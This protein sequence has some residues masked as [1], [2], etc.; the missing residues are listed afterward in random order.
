VEQYNELIGTLNSLV[1]EESTYRSYPPLTAAQKKEMSEKEIELW[2]EKSKCGLVRNDANIESFLSAARSALYQKPEDCEFALYDI[3]IETSSD[4]SDKGKLVIDEDALKNMIE[5]NPQA[6]ES[7]FSSTQDGLAV[8]LNDIIKRTANT[9][10]GSIP[11]WPGRAASA[12]MKSSVSPWGLKTP[13]GSPLSAPCC[14]PLTSSTATPS[15]PR[16]R[17]R[18]W[19]GATMN[20]SSWT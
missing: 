6:I 20:N 5:S 19:P 4:W 8:T 11:F 17:G 9:S 1:D 13:H 18:P 7:L 16:Q 2:E 15:Y 14:A 12:K 3:G 10:S